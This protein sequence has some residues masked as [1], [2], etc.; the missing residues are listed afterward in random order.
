MSSEEAGAAGVTGNVASWD[1]MV[2]RT[3]S[4]SIVVRNVEDSVTQIRQLTEASQGFTAAAQTAY[5]GDHMT[6]NVTVQVPAQQ[7]DGVVSQVRKLAI[8]VQS[9]NSSSQDVT[10]EFTDVQAQIRNLQATEQGL[11][12][13]M[14]RATSVSD[15]I[16]LQRELTNVRGQIERLQGRMNYL[17]RR[18]DMSTIVI[19]VIPEALAKEQQTS[20]GWDPLRTIR[21]AWESSLDVLTGL[22]AVILAIVVFSWWLVPIV[23]FIVWFVR[24]NRRNRPAAPSAA[25]GAGAPPQ[26]PAGSS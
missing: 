14:D 21:E 2:I 17:Q 3:A 16:A 10:E 20:T 13:L 7:F 23:L 24:R 12:K 18:T 11:L 1:R 15:I 4:L 25:P 26:P 22:A 6:A 19:S 8:K 5:K 9:E